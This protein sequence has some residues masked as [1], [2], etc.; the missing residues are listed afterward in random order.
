[1]ERFEVVA[2][3][4]DGERVDAQALK[5]AL[6]QPDARDYLADLLALRELIGHSSAASALAAA[7]PSRRWLIGAAAAVVLSLGGGYALGLGSGLAPGHDGTAVAGGVAPKPTRVIE[8][9]PG[10][11]YVSN[12]PQGER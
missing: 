11:S 7:R 9:A 3:F 6:V 12:I 2:A 1:M 8:V 10:A 4:V 5:L